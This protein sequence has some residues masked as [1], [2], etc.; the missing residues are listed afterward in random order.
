MK[1]N[2]RKKTNKW[3]FF[4]FWKAHKSLPHWTW[5]RLSISYR[6]TISYQSYRFLNSTYEGD[7]NQKK[8]KKT[9]KIGIGCC[10]NIR[11]YI[12]I[13]SSWNRTVINTKRLYSVNR[14]FWGS[15]QTNWKLSMW[16]SCQ[17][18]LP[19]HAWPEVCW[20]IQGEK[21]P[22]GHNWSILLIYKT[23]MCVCRCSRQTDQ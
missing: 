17:H 11:N 2:N 23:S 3:F 7:A 21:A 18:L 15:M 14:W 4:L 8:N 9:N 20:C 10:L 5:K 13:S 19:P 6:L 16:N 12:D 1:L 22:L